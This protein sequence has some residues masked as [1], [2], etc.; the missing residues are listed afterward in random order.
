MNSRGV[1]ASVWRCALLLVFA[2]CSGTGSTISARGNTETS[3]AGVP[4]EAK[5]QV[6]AAYVAARQAE[7]ANDAKYA[8]RAAP[9]G[10]FVAVHPTMRM[11]AELG[12]SGATLS[13]PGETWSATLAGAHYG[14]AGGKIATI[15][16]SA[17]RVGASANRVEYPARAAG[18]TVDEWYVHGPLG[19]EQGFTLS[20]SA[21]RGGGGDLVVEVKLDGL[22]AVTRKD[23]TGLDLRDAGDATRVRYTDLWARDAKGTALVASMDAVPGGIA[24]RVDAHRATFPVTV[25]PMAWVQT[26]ELT[27]SDGAADDSFG[28]SVSLSGT[29]AIIGAYVFVQSGATWTEQAELTA[30]SSVSI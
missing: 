21:C 25:D 6:R 1:F 10:S 8:V 18:V 17:P 24:L 14:C 3:A 22:R 9:G 11:R 28:N 12:A 16:R 26:A 23:G 7:G 4:V 29:T 5:A 20:E 30:G 27:A 15:E 2:S 19:L 13:K